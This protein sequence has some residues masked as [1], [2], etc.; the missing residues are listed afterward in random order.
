VAGLQQNQ[1]PESIEMGG[2][3][4]AESVA[5]IVRNTQ[6][7]TIYCDLSFVNKALKNCPADEDM[8]I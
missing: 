1:W 2:R 8:R 7:C 6:A 4:A 3:F 5:G